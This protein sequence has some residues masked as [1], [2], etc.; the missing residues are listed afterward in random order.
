M[1][2]YGRQSIDEDDIAA[3]EQVLRS[4]FLTQGPMV[5]K[6]E[7]A[8][9]AFCG[10][11]HA[12]AVNSATSALHIA[13]LALGVG[14]GDCVWTSPIT[15]VASANCA[16]YCGATVDFVDI[17]PDTGN[18]CVDALK[19]KLE[20]AALNG[21]LPKALIPVH[22]AGQPCD[23]VELS[24][25]AGKYGIKIIED[26]SHAIGAQYKAQHIGSCAY[27]DIT[28]FS[29]HP[30]KIITTAEGGMALTNDAA[31]AHKMSALRQHGI[32]KDCA[33]LQDKSQG[34]WYYEQHSLGFNYRMTEIQAALGLSQI[35]KLNHFID[36]RHV[37][38]DH[39]DDRLA[40]LLLT[41]LR[42]KADRF[43]SFHLYVVS[44]PE[45]GGPLSRKAVF[46]ALREKAIGVQVHYIPVHLQPFYRSLGFKAGD[47]PCAERFYETAISL[48]LFSAMGQ[49]TQNEVI[50][51]LESVFA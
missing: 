9:A 14:P 39:Y 19:V 1:I 17:E 28:I 44:L 34:P 24:S 45:G 37:L 16:L 4:D 27:S 7:A 20:A 33:E 29:F 51:A 8:V 40:G 30:V 2:P 46:E 13:C 6:F 41:P 36:R 12:V 42:R 47:M 18:M 49:D 11:E 15:F 26:A 43:S 50:A 21:T 5:P 23:M 48:P 3:V 35:N 25:L 22:F 10:A 38:A 32:V 31:L